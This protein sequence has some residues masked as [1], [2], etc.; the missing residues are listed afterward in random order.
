MMTLPTEFEVKTRSGTG[1]LEALNQ[2]P[3]QANQTAVYFD[4]A[5]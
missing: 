5:S 3:K 2:S 4:T 1:D